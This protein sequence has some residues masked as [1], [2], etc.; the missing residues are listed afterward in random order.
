MSLLLHVWRSHGQGDYMQD[1][2][3]AGKSLP[4]S[5]RNFAL[6]KEQ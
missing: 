4:R 1:R 6:Q 5:V 3:S 2:R